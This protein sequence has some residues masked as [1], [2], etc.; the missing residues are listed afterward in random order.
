MREFKSAVG[1]DSSFFTPL[2]ILLLLTAVIGCESTEVIDKTEVTEEKKNYSLAI[3]NLSDQEYPD[4]PDIGFRSANYQNHYFSSGLLVHANLEDKFLI[5][6]EFNGSEGDIIHF[7]DLDISEFIPTIPVGVKKD[8][9]VSYL[10]CIN[11]EWNRNQVRFSPEQFESN[12]PEI[13]RVD[14]ARNCLNAYLW[15]IA[16]YI[17]ENEKVVPYAHAWF[18]FPHVLYAELFEKK[19]ELP[20]ARFKEPLENWVDPESNVINLN[21]LRNVLDSMQVAAEDLS[22]EMYPIAAAREKK[23][24]EIIYPT[25]FNSMRDLQT[26]SALFATFTPPGYYNRADPRKTE[27][28]RFYHLESSIWSNVESKINGDTLSELMLHFR[29]RNDSTLTTLVIGGLDF[30]DFPVLT[31]ENANSGW[32][33][34]MGI[35]NHPFY[36]S[37]DEHM[38]TPSAQNPYYALLLDAEGRWLDSHQ[39]G[40]DGPIFHFSDEERTQLHLWLLS[41]ERHALVGHYEFDI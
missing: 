20:F 32:K 22:E 34:S 10:S 26:D 40:I 37:Y 3:T 19:N 6:L 11:Q 12:N 16:V 31:E 8:E 17:K 7:H 14:I 28:G 24:K 23:F 9:Y 27:L 29:H 13:V 18:D 35:G 4:N 15:E 2:L 1:F 33:S 41:F 38:S 21:L 39:L 5:D 36:E 30:N 25:T